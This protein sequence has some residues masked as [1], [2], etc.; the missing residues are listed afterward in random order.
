MPPRERKPDD[1]PERRAP[2]SVMLSWAKAEE[3]P[4]LTANQ[5]L[6]QIDQSHGQPDAVVL[7]IGYV[8]PPIVIGTNDADTEQ[9]IRAIQEIPVHPLIRISLTRQRLQE[10]ADLLQ[11][12][13][14]NFDTFPERVEG[15]DD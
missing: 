3:M 5:L 7:T 6:A 4:V 14:K 15:E 10:W 1:T 12:T 9:K 13:V 8:P 2:H 11:R